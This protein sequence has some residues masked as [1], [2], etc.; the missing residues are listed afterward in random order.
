[1][2]SIPQ[3][4]SYS[5]P[6]WWGPTR[7]KQLSKVWV[8][9]E[10]QVFFFDTHKTREE[11]KIM[12]K[13]HSKTFAYDCVLSLNVNLVDV[14]WLEKEERETWIKVT[15]KAQ[16][17]HVSYI[18]HNTNNAIKQWTVIPRSGL[19][20]IKWYSA[21]KN[22]VLLAHIPDKMFDMNPNIGNLPGF[23]IGCS[24]LCLALVKAGMYRT[25]PL[26]A[27]ISEMSKPQSAR[28]I[29][30]GRRLRQKFDWSVKSLSLILPPQGSDTKHTTPCV[31][32]V[33]M[34]IFAVLWCL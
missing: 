10:S 4:L 33:P 18:E 3:A 22:G 13:M 7:L 29:T 14:V 11:I 32:V 30:P 26:K 1:M 8:L 27:I 25:P 6:C 31:V 21:L 5:A 17:T 34:R 12:G 2:N 16:Q 19:Q 9:T 15:E 24:K 28:T 20:V 23:L